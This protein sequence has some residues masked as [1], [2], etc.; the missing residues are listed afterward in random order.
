MNHEAEYDQINLM[1]YVKALIKRKRLIFV[2]FLIFVIAAWIFSSYSPKVYKIDTA[3]ELGEVETGTIEETK[4]VIEEPAQVVGKIESDAY[5]IVVRET[6]S[7]SE[8]KYPKIKVK[9]PEETSLIV[10]VITSSEPEMA[11][12]ILKEI[13]ALIV[14]EHV[15]KIKTKKELLE[16]K[17][18]LLEENIGN[19]ERNISRVHTKIASL[20]QE[21]QILAKKIAALQTVPPFE[22][23]PGTQ[24]A[25]FN[26]KE[27][28]EKKKQEVENRYLEI[29]GLENGTNALKG[30]INVLQK[31]GYEIRPTVVLKQPTVSEKPIR[32]LLVIN[33]LLAAVLGIFT[34]IFFALTREWWEKNT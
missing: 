26:A 34:G 10:V 3:L 4:Q 13:N 2:V 23:D 18:V 33:I 16:K 28:L 22:Q 8:E 11:K 9:N 31:K 30:E 14:G 19:S 15:E 21:Q 27:Q 24:F 29:I 7:I 17:I 5:G 32:P 12:N 20:K 1:D 25:L 6:L